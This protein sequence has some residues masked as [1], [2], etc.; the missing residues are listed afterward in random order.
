MT[1]Y[2]HKKGIREITDQQ[3][4]EGT[5]IDGNRIDEALEDV[6]DRVNNVRKGDIST[7]F[8]PN[9]ISFGYLPCRYVANWYATTSTTGAAF[10]NTMTHSSYFTRF[11][12]LPI[13]NDEYT[14]LDPHQGLLVQPLT[15]GLVTRRIQLLPILPSTTRCITTIAGVTRG[16][17]SQGKK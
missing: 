11:P 15:F 16:L 4:S 13:K 3:F 8:V 14:T 17:L 6:E 10:K 12:W 5:T 7:R 2:S 9:K 1:T